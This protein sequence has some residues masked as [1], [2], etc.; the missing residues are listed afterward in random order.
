[1][2]VPSGLSTRPA[3]PFSSAYAFC[4][5]YLEYLPGLESTMC[6]WEPEHNT[7]E[8]FGRRRACEESGKAESYVAVTDRNGIV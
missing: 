3:P 8:G 5:L 1:M 4:E 2:R 6:R 7:P